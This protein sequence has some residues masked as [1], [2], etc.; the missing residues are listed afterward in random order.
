MQRSVVFIFDTE[1]ATP[2]ESRLAMI[3][4][5]ECFEGNEKS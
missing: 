1:A 2:G 5:A 4:V 3:R